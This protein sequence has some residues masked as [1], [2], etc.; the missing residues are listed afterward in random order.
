MEP[1]VGRRYPIRK[2]HK[3]DMNQNFK[4]SGTKLGPGLCSSILKT[5]WDPI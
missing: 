2:R 1:E 3:K 4:G 5:P